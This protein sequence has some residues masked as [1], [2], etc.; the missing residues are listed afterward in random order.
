MLF[1]NAYIFTLIFVVPY[2]KP[3]TK[4]NHCMNMWITPGILISTGKL[5]CLSE[6]AKSTINKDFNVF[7]VS[8]TKAYIK[9]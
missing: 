1:M 7:F 8:N 6:I 5:E 2:K 3:K 9:E 4:K